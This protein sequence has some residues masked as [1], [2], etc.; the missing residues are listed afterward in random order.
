MKK[1]LLLVIVFFLANIS[2]AKSLDFYMGTWSDPGSRGEFY[3]AEWRRSLCSLFEQRG[4]L[5]GVIKVDV[6]QG[7]TTYSNFSFGAVTGFIGPRITFF[8]TSQELFKNLEK[9]GDLHLDLLVGIKV[10]MF[11]QNKGSAPPEMFFNPR[12]NLDLWK[13]KARPEINLNYRAEGSTVSRTEAEGKIVLFE[14]GPFQFKPGLWQSWEKREGKDSREGG[15]LLELK[16]FSERG[17]SFTLFGK[18]G[19]NPEYPK[20]VKYIFGICLSF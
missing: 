6:Y 8:L 11:E 10:P 16:V 1:I 17:D 13:M 15:P 2:S 12:I 7:K 4:E 20:D 3:G 9:K 5:R 14:R 18:A 19:E